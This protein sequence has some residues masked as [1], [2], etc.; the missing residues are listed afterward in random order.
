MAKKILAGFLAVAL[1][2]VLGVTVA[3][4]PAASGDPEIG[5]VTF[6]Y[7][8][9]GGNPGPPDG[10]GGGGD[11]AYKLLRGG[12]KWAEADLPVSY[13]VNVSEAPVVG[14]LAEVIAGFEAWDD[15]TSKE[16]FNDTPVP[17]SENVVSWAP[18]ATAGVIA[19]TT[20][21]FYV[22]TKEIIEFDLVFNSSLGW[23]IGAGGAYYDI[24]NIVTHEA[25]HTL[26]LG[27]LYEDTNS[28]LTMY[29]YAT[30]GEVKKISL[31]NGDIAGVQKLYGE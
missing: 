14:A 7:Y 22:N 6:T 18:I 11:S 12:V 4:A 2:A 19:Q 15:A 28:E 9:K 21:W 31:E 20:I 8:A 10:K 23:G 16:L 5:S 17:A 3:S 25:G 27:D 24:R 30:E 1:I 13:T 26:H 29:G